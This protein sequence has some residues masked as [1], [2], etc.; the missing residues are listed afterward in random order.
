MTQARWTAVLPLCL[1][2][3]S[4]NG[5]ADETINIARANLAL[6][7]L[8]D[9]GV[10]PD[11]APSGADAASSVDAGA[12]DTGPGA[13]AGPS[14]LTDRDIAAVLQTVDGNEIAEAQLALMKSQTL[15]V[16]IFAQQMITDHTLDTRQVGQVLTELGTTSTPNA[17]SMAFAASGTRDL[18]SLTSLSGASFDMAY[19]MLAVDSHTTLLNTITETLIPSAMSDE[20]KVLLQ[21]YQLLINAHLLEAQQLRSGLPS[22]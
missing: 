19:A 12:A 18:Q 21:N 8:I 6:L 7:I 15:A 3:C 11:A 4:N 9:S 5:G 14:A 16:R 13:D 17:V 22:P 1:V 20:M 10:T 2:A